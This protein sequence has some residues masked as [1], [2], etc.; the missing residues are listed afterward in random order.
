MVWLLP[1]AEGSQVWIIVVMTWLVSAGGFMH[2]VAGSMEA[3]MLMLDGSVS[4]VQVFGGFIAPVLIGN[5]IGGTA[6]FALLTYAQ[7]MKEME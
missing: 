4:V 6:L 5:V 1:S 2:I 3:F 7:V